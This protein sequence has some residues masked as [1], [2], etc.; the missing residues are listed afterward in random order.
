MIQGHGLVY[1]EE[2]DAIYNNGTMAQIYQDVGAGFLRWP[3]GTVATMY[4]WNNLSGVG[5][6]DNWNPSYND[7][8]DRPAAEFMDLNEYI[9]LTN[10]AGTEPMLGIN[11]S[12]GMEWN[13]EADAIQEA[14]DMINYCLNNGFNVKYFYLDNETYHHGN[15]YNKDVDGDNEEWTPLL[16]AQ[17]INVYAA[18]IKA[19][20]PDAILIANWTDKV[21]TNI[22]AYTTIINTAGNNIDYIDVHWYWKWGVANWNAWKATTPM[23]NDTDW[24]DGGTFVEEIEYFNNLTTSLGKPHIKLAALEWN[25]AP[26]DFHSNPAHTEFMQ[27]L[28][29]SEMQLQFIQGGLELAAM[30]TTQWADYANSDF[31]TLVDSDDNYSPT[32]TALMLELYKNAINGELVSSTISDNQILTATILKGDKVYVY[33]LSKDDAQN[34]VEFNFTGVDVLSVHEAKRFKD[35]GVLQDIGLWNHATRGSYM[36]NIQANTLTMVA[37]ERDLT[38]NMLLN[39]DFEN[40]LNH[41]TPWNG[42]TNTTDAFEGSS[43]LNMIDKGSVYQWVTV[44]P[45]TEYTLSAY[46]KTSNAA[47]RVVMIIADGDEVNQYSTESYDT[48]Y[49]LHQITFTTDVDQTQLK[50]SIWQPPSGTVTANADDVQLIKTNNVLGLRENSIDNTFKIY[51]NPAKNSISVSTYSNISNAQIELFDMMGNQVAKQQLNFSNNK[52]TMSVSNIS[53]GIYIAVVSSKDVK[54]EVSKIVL[55]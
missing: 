30:W 18:A 49:T 17:K 24:Y 28:M 7:A 38:Q 25:I 54:K 47:N 36:A 43:A 22:S 41:W 19:L 11:M 16:Y 39:G 33:I 2:D 52:T 44:E 45:D 55:N 4:H 53:R 6:I 12:S 32:P 35:P 13:R 37:F 15:G 3:G 14:E 9:T 48:A 29:Q 26:G 10:A 46:L 42:P 5:W 21:R 27:A 1:S 31:M 50:V 40:A 23:E 34:N 20:V 8:N 51:P